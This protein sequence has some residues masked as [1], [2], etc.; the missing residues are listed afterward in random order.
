MRRARQRQL[1]RMILVV[2]FVAVILY[3]ARVV[4]LPIAMSAV[5]CYLVL[6]AVRFLEGRRTAKGLAAAVSL[7]AFFA[8]IIGVG[9]W[10]WP[11]LC[12]DFAALSGL[13]PQAGVI[14]EQVNSGWRGMMADMEGGGLMYACLSRAFDRMS[15]ILGRV[16]EQSIAALPGLV[17]SLSLLVFTPIFA[18]YLLRDREGLIRLL[19]RSARPLIMDLNQIMQAFV[20]GYLLVAL[21]V[22]VLFGGLV[23]VF[24]LGYS[25]TLGLIMLVAELI[26]Y[27]GPFLAFFPCVA[28]GL[29][30]G[31]L[32][33]IKL[34]L[35]WFAVQQLENLL[36]TPHIMSGVMRLPPFYIML[37]VLI[38]G[39][40]WGVFGMVLA[41]PLAAALRVIGN[42]AA[43]WWRMNEGVGKEPELWIK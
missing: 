3:L 21:V 12:R 16:L 43:Q 13:A 10:G 1:A 14:L 7:V 17:G 36:I 33:L 38:G 37:A 41:V 29:V 24:G 31:R 2:V 39:F 9:L 30:Q 6:P 19:P 32:A 11:R 28:L 42:A 4:L 34:L 22:G 27:L 18:F 35:I 5:L 20:R 26:P 23:W 8:L 15:E 25:F 40:W